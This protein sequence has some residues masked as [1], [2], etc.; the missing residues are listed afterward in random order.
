ML[1]VSLQVFKA[2]IRKI[3]K[4]YMYYFHT[5]KTSYRRRQFYI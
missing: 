4:T 1:N 5:M 2:Q 3:E